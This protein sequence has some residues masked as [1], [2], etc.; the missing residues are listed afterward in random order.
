MTECQI[1]SSSALTGYVDRPE[2]AVN[3]MC[4]SFVTFFQCLFAGREL[5]PY[6][7][8]FLLDRSATK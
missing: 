8:S 2:S 3:E 5:K 7:L 1:F 4:S 6:M